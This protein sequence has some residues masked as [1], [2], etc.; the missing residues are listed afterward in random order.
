M[1]VA[2]ILLS[3]SADVPAVSSVVS[4][5]TPADGA[6]VTVANFRASGLMDPKGA[7][8][9][10]WDYGAA[11]VVIWSSHGESLV[12]KDLLINPYVGNGVK[13]LAMVLK[14]DGVV[15]ALLSGS[16]QLLVTT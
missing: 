3:A 14:N 10:Y 5:M 1:P 7:V 12:T 11:N 15:S 2:E 4:E 9:L 16:A 8:I 6:V 13:K